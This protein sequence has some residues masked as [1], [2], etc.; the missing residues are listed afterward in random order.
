MSALTDYFTSLAN[1]IR[2]ILGGQSTYTPAQM[3]YALDDIYASGE[4]G[5]MVGTALADDV[6]AGKTFTNANGVGI[7]GTF[8][9]TETF[10]ASTRAVDLDMGADH[11]K[12]YVDTSGIPNLNTDSY[13][14][15]TVAANVDMGENN[16]VR[17]L[18]TLAFKQN[19]S[20]MS[21]VYYEYFT[22]MPSVVIFAD[23]TLNTTWRDADLTTYNNGKMTYSGN[24]TKNVHI[25]GFIK[26]GTLT[27]NYKTQGGTTA[28]QTM[29][30]LVN[31][32]SFNTYKNPLGFWVSA[33]SVTSD[34]RVFLVVFTF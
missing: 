18:N 1:K 26:S 19:L 4:S 17:W 16:V 31:I 2:S 30:D 33:T 8:T 5:A 20:H 9:H 12:R 13:T 25:S 32:A 24:T 23:G 11:K 7:Q 21:L 29:T 28:T 6:K 34:T 22:A 3:V 14:P 27:L 15:D 10:T